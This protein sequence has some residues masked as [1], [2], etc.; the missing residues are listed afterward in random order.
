MSKLAGVNTLRDN[1]Y[2]AV[3]DRCGRRFWASTMKVDPYDQAFVD[4][5]CYDGKH[6]GD[7]SKVIYEDRKVPIARDRTIVAADNSFAQTP[8]T[9]GSSNDGLWY[10]V[11]DA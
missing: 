2:Y 8:A 6:D 10:V 9:A 1:D 4:D 3:C 7:R 11:E 5:D